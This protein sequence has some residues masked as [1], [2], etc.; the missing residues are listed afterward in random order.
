ML[1]FDVGF[2]IAS[3]S[4]HRRGSEKRYVKCLAC[5]LARASL[6]KRGRGCYYV[7]VSARGTLG[8]TLQSSWRQQQYWVSSERHTTHIGSIISPILGKHKVRLKTKKPEVHCVRRKKQG[9]QTPSRERDVALRP[10]YQLTFPCTCTPND[11]LWD[12]LP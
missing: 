1:T 10:K 11:L 12:T 8:S 7:G 6:R 5:S 9:E 3:P 4:Q 2:T